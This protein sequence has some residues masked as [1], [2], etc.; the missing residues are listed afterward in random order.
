MSYVLSFLVAVAA[1]IVGDYVSKWLDG[2][3]KSGK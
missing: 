3:D 1:R 2:H